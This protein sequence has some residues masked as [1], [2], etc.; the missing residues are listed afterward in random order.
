MW[1]VGLVL[2]RCGGNARWPSRLS[3]PDGKLSAVFT[4]CTVCTVNFL[5]KMLWSC[6]RPGA[7]E[8]YSGAISAHNVG[9]WSVESSFHDNH[10]SNDDDLFMPSNVYV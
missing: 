7:L 1:R 5:V 6:Y 2:W 3:G 4:A 10:Y 9:I 8:P